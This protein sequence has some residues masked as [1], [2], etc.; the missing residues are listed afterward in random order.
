MNKFIVYVIIIFEYTLFYHLITSS[1]AVQNSP[2]NAKLSPA[3][4][5]MSQIPS[6]SLQTAPK[7]LLL[8]HISA[9]KC[10][11][12]VKA[13][14]FSPIPNAIS[15]NYRDVKRGSLIA[16]GC[17]TSSPFIGRVGLHKREGN[18]TL[19]SFGAE[20]TITAED[21]SDGSQALSALLPVVVALTAVSAL[22][23]PWTFTWWGSFIVLG[24]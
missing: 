17:S 8:R 13:N 22:W 24:I 21:K 23:K 10:S 20:N 12:P 2:E 18:F 19:L 6:L 7:T 14:I 9:S 3:S 4:Q 1:A 16:V 5:A 15:R 11:I